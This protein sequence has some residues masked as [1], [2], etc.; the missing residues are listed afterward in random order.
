MPLRTHLQSAVACRQLSVQRHEGTCSL[1][2]VICVEGERKE[3]RKEEKEEKRGRR[4]GK[5]VSPE[6]NQT[7]K[8]STRTTND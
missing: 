2:S 7:K 3:Q 1:P 4:G 8:Q 5:I 6:T